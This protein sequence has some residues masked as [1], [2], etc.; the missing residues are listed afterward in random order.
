MLLRAVLEANGKCRAKGAFRNLREFLDEALDD[1][2]AAEEY[3]EFDENGAE[4]SC[5]AVQILNTRPASLRVGV[6]QL[7]PLPSRRSL[8]DLK[9]SLIASCCIPFW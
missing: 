9:Q 6:T 7:A 5:E 1:L 4:L 8:A 2:F 3:C